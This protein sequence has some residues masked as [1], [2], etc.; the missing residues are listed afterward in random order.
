MHLAKYFG[1]IDKLKGKKLT[2]SWAYSPSYGK[3]LSVP[4]GIV[5]LM[6]RF[7][8][9]VTLAY[10]EGYDLIPEIVELAK[11]NAEETESTFTVTNSMDE[12]F[13]DADI[14][15]PKSWAP[16]SIMKRRVE[17]PSREGAE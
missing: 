16:Y 10:P 1:G 3:P 9:N 12:A 2:M 15:Y 13:K 4:Q 14:V 11:K 7:G 5:G 17:L 6:T 8:M